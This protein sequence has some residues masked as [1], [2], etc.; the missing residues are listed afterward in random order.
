MT[1]NSSLPAAD[2]T[3][4][5]LLAERPVLVAPASGVSPAIAALEARQSGHGYVIGRDGMFLVLN[6][7]WLRLR[8]LVADP[9]LSGEPYGLAGPR[10]L[11]ILCGLIPRDIALEATAHFRAALPDE[12]GGFVLWDARSGAFRFEASRALEATPNRLVYAI[13]TPR[14]GE[15]VI[16]D[17]H[18]HGAAPAFW[19]PTDDA[20]DVHHTRLSLVFGSFSPQAPEGRFVARLCAAGRMFKIRH[21]PFAPAPEAPALEAPR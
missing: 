5:A 7:P 8:A 16:A 17:I 9:A 4:L 6:R 1:P 18:S 14:P 3:A 10:A 13:P 12:A 11:D 15:H 2:P 21:S 20:D 19:S